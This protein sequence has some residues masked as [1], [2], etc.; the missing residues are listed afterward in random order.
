MEVQLCRRRLRRR[1]F[2]YLR[3]AKSHVRRFVVVS[4]R[5]GFSIAIPISTYGGHGLSQN[6][7]TTTRMST[8]EQR[9]HSIIYSLGAE[10]VL[11]DG[12]DYLIKEPICVQLK[13]NERLA[14]SARLYYAKPQSINHNTNVK[15]L[16]RVIKGD[17]P[18][19]LTDYR[20]ECS[21]ERL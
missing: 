17:I 19:L 20:S 6:A 13:A 9:A 3:L 5:E 2:R 12:E 16:G 15:Y 14:S 1:Y 4:L 10:P 7:R 21:I 18:T 8:L 11:I